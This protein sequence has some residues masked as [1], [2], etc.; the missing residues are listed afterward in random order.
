[1][2]PD[3]AAA[4]RW[5]GETQGARGVGSAKVIIFRFMYKCLARGARPFLLLGKMPIV[6]FRGELK[7]ALE[8]F[9]RAGD[10]GTR[11]GSAAAGK[12]SPFYR[13]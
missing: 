10:D 12:P 5:G 8:A 4:S 3:A 6:K 11:G 13:P 2:S 9:A 1:M 7:N